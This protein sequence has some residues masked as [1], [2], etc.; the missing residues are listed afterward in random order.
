MVIYSKFFNPLHFSKL[1]IRE[2]LDQFRNSFSANIRAA[3]VLQI[4]Y[5]HVVVLRPLDLRYGM[6]LDF[7]DHGFD[8]VDAFQFG[9]I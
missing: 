9:Q 8:S 7:M 6:R 3:N 1:V 5:V 4:I 2:S